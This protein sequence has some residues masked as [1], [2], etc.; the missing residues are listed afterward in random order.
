[1]CIPLPALLPAHLSSTPRVLPWTGQHYVSTWFLID[2]LT[3]I[4]FQMIAKAIN[5]QPIICIDGTA[6]FDNVTCGDEADSSASDLTTLRLVRVLRLLR[7]VK[8]LRILR[9]SRIIVRWQV[10]R[11]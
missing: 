9:A 3:V 1:M 6:L 7:L 5:G 11:A 2:L 8:L 10:G 4:D